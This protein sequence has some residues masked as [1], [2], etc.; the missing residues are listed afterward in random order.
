MIAVLL[1]DDHA[2]VRQGIRM[3]VA[4][5]PD[6]EVVGESGDGLEGV[7]LACELKPDVLVM[8]VGLPRLDGIGATERLR[9][10]A[11]AVRVV[12]LTVHEDDEYLVRALRAGAHGFV[13][14]RA[15]G[16]DLVAAV[17]AVHR[18]D[19]Y[20]HSSMTGA[21]VSD[22]L[23]RVE[24]TA[25]ERDGLTPREV[26]VLKLVAAGLTT[27]AIADRLTVSAKTVQAHR[28]NIMR[29]LDVHDRTG[30][31]RYAIVNGMVEA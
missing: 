7:R 12:I 8:D 13:P 4:S 31:V 26:E 3:V 29:K 5:E 19:T 11:P 2:M 9:R 6:M 28:A 20:I 30:L 10:E 14:K 18:G 22:Y 1:V 21:L 25:E 27:S 15:A 24:L 23:R 16:Q 17:R